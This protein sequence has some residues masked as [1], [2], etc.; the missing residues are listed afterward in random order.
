VISGEQR[1][2]STALE[3]LDNNGVIE[4]RDPL[5]ATQTISPYS[6]M[7][8][9]MVAE[10]D[11][12]QAI[13][14]AYYANVYVYR[15]VFQCAQAISGLP[16]RVGKDPE[17]PDVFSTDA[18]MAVLLSPPPGGPAPGVSARKLFAWTIAQY[19]ITGKYAWEIECE[20]KR[21]KGKI[22][23]LWPLV[24]CALYPEPTK[25]GSAYF[26]GYEYGKPGVMNT[27]IK[28][29]VPEQVFYGW[30][31][32]QHDY[33]QP[34]SALMAAR[35]NIS[36]AVMQ[37]RYD[38]AFLRN[39]ARPAAIIVHEAFS[40]TEERDAFM[41]AFRGD[42]RGPDNAGKALFVQATGEDGAGV[43]GAMDVKTLGLSQRDGQFIAR[44]AQKIND[45]CVAL[46][47][48]LSILGDSTK[49]TYD[50][51]NVEHRNWWESTLQ[52]L[53]F[54]IADEI[55]M[56]I[57][58]RMGSEVGWFDFSQIKA[59]QS[60][61]R[62]LALGPT[63]P[64]LVGPGK[65]ITY[66]E[67]RNELGLTE[68]R[69]ADEKNEEMVATSAAALADKAGPQPPAHSALPPDGT[70]DKS[71]SGTQLHPPVSGPGS[72]SATGK[73]AREALEIR[74]RN[75]E[76]RAMQWR[77]IDATAKGLEPVFESTMKA[78]FEKQAAS[79]FARLGGRR[80]K[81]LMT[82]APGKDA[83]DAAKIAYIEE[84]MRSIFDKEFWKLETAAAI[85]G[86]YGAISAAAIAA[87]RQDFLEAVEA[88]AMDDVFDTTNP[89]VVDF[90]MARANQLAGQISETTYDQIQEALREG[91]TAG[92]DIPAIA[93]RIQEVFSDADDLRATTIART[94]V[95]SA[96]NGTTEL[97]GTLLPDDVANGKAW[98]TTMDGRERDAHADADEQQ[99]AL[100]QPFQVGGEELLYPGDPS[101][102]PENCINC[103]CAVSL[104]APEDWDGGQQRAV[105][106]DLREIREGLWQ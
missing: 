42:F 62:L 1:A 30:R 98:I 44:Y 65:P 75:K 19:L 86:T 64:L 40:R 6:T 46:G 87:A 29:F 57:A 35:L 58:P 14:L 48:P 10:W 88:D 43:Q 22:V 4:R 50:A 16:F 83:L 15:C 38:F 61:S 95:I 11:A 31:P 56:Q 101:G 47:T 20:G 80:G 5:G 105:Q 41:R 94:E 93:D 37:D 60:D 104:L 8:K 45:I 7:S 69:P 92:D 54:E 77:M 13:K 84:V 68:L 3:R 28:H 52:P 18:P 85:R 27:Q 59:L 55:N 2:L 66:S 79:V 91:V 73:L 103:R 106:L 90:I 39:D 82:R 34:E 71:P 12:D 74:A 76:T 102:S 99:V 89:S 26:E 51:A 24:S 78:L 53:C 49:R 36:V 81:S 17:K 72:G 23:N 70:P 63:L 32:S 25:G 21:G 97:L 9:T 96:Y 33:R 67:F 100:G